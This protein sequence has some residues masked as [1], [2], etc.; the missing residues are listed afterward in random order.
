[1]P[2]LQRVFISYILFYLYYFSRSLVKVDHTGI[3]SA[4]LCVFYSEKKRDAYMFF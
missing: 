4:Y 2:C 3:D 1:M